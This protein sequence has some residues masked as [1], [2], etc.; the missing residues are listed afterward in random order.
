LNKL[1]ESYVKPLANLVIFLVSDDSTYCT[2]AEFVIDG[3]MI[4]DL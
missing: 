4:C 3:G 1:F 2:G